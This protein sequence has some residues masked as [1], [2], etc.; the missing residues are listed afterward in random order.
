MAF[1]E[2]FMR[3]ARQELSRLERDRK[4]LDIRIGTLKQLLTPSLF[5]A[6]TTAEAN[7]NGSGRTT[8]APKSSFKATVLG[9]IRE[10][11]GIVTPGITKTLKERGVVVGGNTEMGHRVYNEIYRMKN[12]GEIAEHQGGW[13]AVKD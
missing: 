11:P 1:S 7:P 6:A 12:N 8:H 5:D 9:V 3:E 10:H 13:V 2:S 4:E